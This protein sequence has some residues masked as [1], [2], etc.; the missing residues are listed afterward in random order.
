MRF[1]YKVPGQ[2]FEYNAEKTDSGQK[3][4]EWMDMM[5]H[6]DD[7]L[8]E[9]D[10]EQSLILDCLLLDSFMVLDFVSSLISFSVS[11]GPSWAFTTPV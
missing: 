1:Q 6:S 7:W 11:S 4:C 9:C 8:N 5:I 3:E 2:K 10:V